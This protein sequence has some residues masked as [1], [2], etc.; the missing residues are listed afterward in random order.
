MYV[1]S[2][3]RRGFFHNCWWRD[4][5]YWSRNG[6]PPRKRVPGHVAQDIAACIYPPPRA[7]AFL[8][9]YN[10][11]SPTMYKTVSPRHGFDE[12][13][14]ARHDQPAT[15]TRHPTLPPPEYAVPPA[16]CH[17]FCY[18]VLSCPV[19]PCDQ[20]GASPLRC[21]GNAGT[22]VGAGLDDARAKRRRR[23]GARRAAGC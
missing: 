21:T 20:I 17:A 1:R 14:V 23:G 12:P 8:L 10:C 9:H 18:A 16:S 5:L 13:K 6:T 11:W 7:R 19:M 2:A 4:L 22:P 15:R 3:A